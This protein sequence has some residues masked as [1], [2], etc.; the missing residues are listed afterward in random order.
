MFLSSFGHHDREVQDVAVG[1]FT[2]LNPK[3]D[4]SECK[5][6]HLFI[7]VAFKEHL[8]SVDAMTLVQ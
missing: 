8:F 3:K 7:L 1:V 2:K 5:T 4:V 6:I